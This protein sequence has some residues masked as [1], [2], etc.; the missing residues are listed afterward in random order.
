[1]KAKDI[2]SKMEKMNCILDDEEPVFKIVDLI[3]QSGLT[4]YRISKDTGIPQSTLNYWLSGE[5]IANLTVLKLVNYLSKDPED[6]K[7]NI[8][9]L[10]KK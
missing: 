10:I 5:R 1:M 3:I 6:L 2:L 7:E 8:E 4:T 9:K